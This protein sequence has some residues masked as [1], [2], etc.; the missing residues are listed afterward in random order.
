MKFDENSDV[1][2]VITSCGRFDLLKLTLE[3]FNLHN[4]YPIKEVILI[5][6]AGKKEVEKVIPTGWLAN[7]KIIINKKKLGQIKSIDLAYSNIVTDYI[8]HCEDDWLFYRSG[9]IED[10]R[11]ILQSEPSI[12]QVRLRDYDNDIKKNYPFHYPAEKIMLKNI[13]YYKLGSNDDDWRGFSF[14]P[15][16][17]RKS[18]YDKIKPYFCNKDAISTESFL[19]NIYFE[20]GMFVVFLEKSAIKHIGWDRHLLSKNEKKQKIKKSKRKAILISIGFLIGFFVC[21]LTNN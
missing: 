12:L 10:S 9:F 18:D 3:S 2:L 11:L 6:D 21:Y 15:S 7:T 16:L 1:T 19:S 5:E 4:T 14:N 8:F 20:K 13:Q 17:K